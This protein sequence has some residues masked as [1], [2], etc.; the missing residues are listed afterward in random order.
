MAKDLQMAASGYQGK[1][2]YYRGTFHDSHKVRLSFLDF[3][4]IKKLP[5]P[6]HFQQIGF[7]L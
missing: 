2:I 5:C 6:L 4:L 1:N 3:V 7:N